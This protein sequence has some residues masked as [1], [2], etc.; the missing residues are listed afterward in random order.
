MNTEFRRVKDIFLSALERAPGDKREAYLREICGDD[1]ALRRQVDALLGRHEQAGSLLEAAPARL[2]TTVART[3]T[4]ERPGAMVGPYKLLEQ[5]GEGGFGVVFMAEQTH[6]VRRR[7]A[8]KILKLGM[9]SRQV[10]ARFEA[11]RQALALMDHPN[12]A[13]VFDGGETDSGR[14][15]FVMEL[16]KGAPITDSCNQNRL[17]TRQRLELFV[18]VCAAVQHAHQKGIIHRD[19]KPSNVLVS[20]HD[21]TPVVRVIDFGIAKALGQELTD[22]TL[23]TGFGQMIGTP[24]YMSPEQA[25]MSDLDVDTRSDVYSLGVL[26]YELLT[27]TT[28]FLKDR[29]RQ[30][31]YD[32]IRRIIREEEPPRPSTRLSESG[33][34]LTTI[35]AQRQ[36]DPGRL[37]K[38]VRG[39][40]D[41]IVMKALE[42]DR[43]RRYESPG[44]FAAD[45]QRYLADEPVQARPPSAGYRLRKFLRRNRSRVLAAGLILFFV[46]LV[47]AGAGWLAFDRAA[48]RTKAGNDFD[49][50]RER[51]EMFLGQGKRAEAREAFEQTRRLALDVGSDPARAQ[52]LADLQERL[53]AAERDQDFH[54]WFERLRLEG[55]SEVLIE[56]TSFARE[57]T[58]A[59]IRE[60]LR[61]YGLDIGVMPREQ[62]IA[63]IQSRPAMVRQD[64]V[65]ALEECLSQA[66]KDEKQMREWLR[67]VLDPGDDDAWRAR[68]RRAKAE[69][70]WKTLEQL[71]R[72]ADVRKHPQN[73]LLLVGL[74]L[75]KEMGASRLTLYQRI[76]HAYP[77]DLWANMF[78][79]EELKKHGRA[80]ESV[81]YH[82]AVVA[83][84]PLN[85]G[86]YANRAIALEAAGELEAAITD[87]ERALALA[88]EYFWV[89][90]NLGQ[91]LLKAHRKERAAAE[92]REFLRYKPDSAPAH[93]N[94]GAALFPDHLDECI[95]EHR[96]AIRLDKTLPEVHYNL[97]NALI[98]KG[99]LDG[100]IAAHR[101]AIRL[102]DDYAG[103][104]LF[105][106]NALGMKGQVDEAIAEFH[107]ALAIKK[108]F[109][110]AR[111]C[112]GD[113]L[114][115]KQRPTD[116][117]REYREAIRIQKDYAEAHFGLA[118]VLYDLKRL[119]DAIESFR[120]VIRIQKDH[121]GAHTNLGNAHFLKD[122]F[123]DAIAAYRAAIKLKDDA[124][125]AH[126]GLGNALQAKGD[127]DGA[128]AAYR[129]AIEI[130]KNFADAHLQLG[131]ALL[132]L[133]R[134]EA[135]A[136]FQ[137]A[138]EFNPVYADAHVQLGDSWLV[139]G[140]IA[141][142][143]LE[144]RIALR[145]NTASADAHLGL[146][147]TF[148]ERRRFK[149]AIDVYRA[150]I[151][152]KPADALAH[153]NLGNF[154]RMTDDPDGAAAEFRSAIKLRNDFPQAHTNLGHILL[155]KD[156]F[157][158]AMAEF[159]EALR[160]KLAFSE[161]Y[162]AHTGLGDALAAKGRRAEALAEYLS[163]VKL[164]K[165]YHPAHYGLGNMYFP[166]QLEK[167]IAA[168][169]QAIALEPNDARYHVN[170]G[171]SLAGMGELDDAITEYRKAIKLDKNLFE[172]H[173]N[174]GRALQFKDR[175][176]DAIAEYRE[177]IRLNKGS[178]RGH[179]FLGGALQ[180]LG[181]LDEAIAAFRAAQ[182]LEKDYPEVQ[183]RLREAER[184]AG[185]AKRLPAILAGK[186]E[187]KDAAEAIGLAQICQTKARKQYAAAV[188]F[189]SDAFARDKTLAENPETWDRYN[190]AC[191]AAL[192]AAGQGKDADGLDAR[193]RARLRQL[194]LDW[195]RAD[196]KAWGRVIDKEPGKARMAA[197][198]LNRWSE[199][200]DFAGVRGP[201][202][203]AKLPED[204]QKLWQALWDD[205]AEQGKRAR[206]KI[207]PGK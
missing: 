121:V 147:N 98:R 141:K 154:L 172:A 25:G 17:S 188:R 119:D 44:A 112:L 95:A 13:K 93:T 156:D 79:A 144:Y 160:T 22:K 158:G 14:P 171:N 4:G 168:Y 167:A 45:V 106:G 124:H 6:P 56:Q 9:D 76:Q 107:K 203:L 23:F 20:Q 87:N 166:D 140:K 131:V 74:S 118:N 65:A 60:G 175:L 205:V 86:V 196:L 24:L 5:L 148:A 59:D 103:A 143:A 62:A 162:K 178:A 114:H 102:R 136:E 206:A 150:G 21:A 75:P 152:L 15:Y 108:D 8:L 92:Y 51:T 197:D 83:L 199:D 19:I 133:R 46:A 128:V 194:A 70:D 71:A 27:G 55:Q 195:L 2:E 122:A 10:V 39:D 139:Q 38:Q 191:A 149:E 145:L 41:W 89:H 77:G 200:S 161:A 130:K 146:G 58:F 157:D 182:R 43:N 198:I 193:E 28:P 105:L 129:R 155:D 48:R 30:V 90:N 113:A 111:K 42:K 31:S 1:E 82:T 96:E 137:K 64:L 88:P 97:G 138:I 94:L 7:V 125:E 100:A 126:F 135:I 84:R 192:A 201:E 68:V 34:T 73:F 183:E 132:P 29:F 184:L 202:A 134:D 32:E 85:P 204:E 11:E 36:T 12:I 170:L 18:T 80:A 185:L 40:L 54:F 165:G 181:E 57:Y 179:F 104:H 186:D 151:R 53:E 110:E 123:D 3:E 99:D 33:D 16:V 142:A 37:T 164:N 72:E 63:L 173:L 189:F 66:P 26:L 109:A 117:I 176:E 61:R 78:L 207:T 91:V 163:A 159:R 81:R 115:D 180:E 177:A 35:S 153:Y 69:R 116:A 190:A 127:P 101:E 187:A 169:R 52:R 49:L 50:A 67:A 47:A 174:L 120:D